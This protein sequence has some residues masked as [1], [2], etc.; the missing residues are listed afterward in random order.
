MCRCGRKDLSHRRWRRTA[1]WALRLDVVFVFV[2]VVA[3]GCS[4]DGTAARNLFQQHTTRWTVE[5]QQLRH[6][7]RELDGQLRG[8]PALNENAPA[9]DKASRLRLESGVRS[10]QQLIP[11][12]E[13]Q[14]RDSQREF[15]AA[16]QRGPEPAFVAV[17]AIDARITGLLRAIRQT[18][19]ASTGA[20][21]VVAR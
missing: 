7:Q 10:A 16:A 4:E 3:A 12:I 21:A 5:L 17:T 20:L 11:D 14:L 13:L 6:L 2:A 18:L 19:E 1:D 15:D 9:A 8:L